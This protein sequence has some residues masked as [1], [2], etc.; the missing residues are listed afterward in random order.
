MRKTCFLLFLAIVVLSLSVPSRSSAVAAPDTVAGKAAA[1]QVADFW[2]KV[3]NGPAP[4]GVPPLNGSRLN[5]RTIGDVTLWDAGFDSYRDPDTNR[6]AR[7]SGILAVPNKPGRTFPGLVVTHSVGAQHPAPDNV[8]EMA[9][10]FAGQGYVTLA[11]YLRGYGTSRLA[12]L[13]VDG[14]LGRF[15]GYLCANLTD[16]GEPLDTVWAGFPVDTFQAGEFLAAQ[17]EVMDPNRLAFIGHSLGGLAALHAGIFSKRYKVIVTS[18]PAMTSPNLDAAMEYW[19]NSPFQ[20]WAESQPDSKRA[21]A[22]LT[23]VLSYAGPYPALNNPLLAAKNRD[24]K[25]KET[26]IWFYGGQNDPSIPPQDVE[27]AWRLADS[28]NKKV[29]HWSPTGTHGGPE[30]WQPGQAWLAGHYPGRPQTPPKAD[31]KVVSLSGPTAVFSA[32]KSSAANA[33]VSWEY[34]FGDGTSQNWGDSIS[35]TYARPGNYT[36]KLTATDGAGLWDTASVRVVVGGQKAEAPQ[37][38]SRE[39]AKSKP[40][41]QAGL[42]PR[43]TVALGEARGQPGDA[44][45]VPVT[46]T[47]SESL[48]ISSISL[49]VTFDSKVIGQPRASRGL[50]MP[51]PAWWNFSFSRPSP[52]TLDFSADQFVPAP[53]PVTAGVMAHL[54]FTVDDSAPAGVYAVTI[55]RA[56]INNGAASPDTQSGSVK[57]D[58]R[59]K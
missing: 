30:S 12:K 16:E 24:W 46:L 41:D 11:F 6:P 28:S 50:A 34:D 19:K 32:E 23:R 59:R 51:G 38:A 53:S 4:H 42:N 44:V 49:T 56:R 17:P 2:A 52:G 18:A 29:F 5:R 9:T 7:L 54:V 25:L 10:F 45:L 47:S 8:E 33:L 15:A 37:T 36:V 26:A 31:L 39:S 27:A 35:H 13:N 20:R 3:F 55:V 21:L 48:P 1:S 14:P 58:V 43:F 57:I 22:R 40:A